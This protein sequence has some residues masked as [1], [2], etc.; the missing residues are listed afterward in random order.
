MSEVDGIESSSERLPGLGIEL[1][2]I[3]AIGTS[4]FTL[5]PFTVFIGK[6]AT[7]KSY[8]ATVVYA[9]LNALSARRWSPRFQRQAIVPVPHSPKPTDESQQRFVNLVGRLIDQY[10]SGPP[11]KYEADEDSFATTVDSL[12]PSDRTLCMKVIEE[13]I[14][15]SAESVDQELSRCF[16]SETSSLIR[17]GASPPRASIKWTSSLPQIEGDIEV[18]STGITGRGKVASVGDLRL[19]IPI[20]SAGHRGRPT[21]EE[22]SNIKAYSAI[23]ARDSLWN[24]ALRRVA[25]RAHFLPAARSGI[26]HTHRLAAA[27]WMQEAPMFGLRRVDVPVVAGTVSDFLVETI[28]AGAQRPGPLE[29]IA[30]QIERN[31][32]HGQVVVRKGRTAYPDIIF[33][34]G[35]EEFPLHLASSMISELAPLVLTIRFRLHPEELLIIEEPE[36]HLHPG[37][38]V[39]FARAI[40]SLVRAGVRVMVTTHS[41]YFL[42]ELNNLIRSGQ[43]RKQTSTEAPPSE[44]LDSDEQSRRWSIVTRSCEP[45]MGNPS[46]N[47]STSTRR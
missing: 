38:Q 16:G 34:E 45:S 31:V 8:A 4:Q 37:G 39:S 7:A 17:R 41:D 18:A 44:Y 3:G 13:M 42:S 23:S 10:K 46:G 15:A 27:A 6:N 1:S 12:E 43:L 22:A 24:A 9:L 32:L 25:P 2:N 19:I 28:M 21:Q 40:S 30:D 20:L 47:W 26:M 33:K 11:D 36:A 29:K 5:Y 14:V 35:R